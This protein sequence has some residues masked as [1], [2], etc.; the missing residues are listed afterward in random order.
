MEVIMEPPLR[1]L[2]KDSI[3]VWIWKEVIE[4]IIG[5]AVLI[6][7]FILDRMFSW[8]VWAGWILYG[9]VGLTVMGMIWAVFKVKLLQK[10]W[11]YGINEDFLY[12]KSGALKEEYKVIPMTK[13]QS[14]STNEGPLLKKY[15]LSS[16]EVST[17]GRMH[18][19]PALPKAEA[20]KLRQQIALYSNVEEEDE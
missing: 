5:T 18:V 6:V 15:N 9:L 3:K 17:I 2:S 13:V 12:V 4:N 7:L 16:V 8:P 20:Q 14:V 1:R 10:Q 19:I 11:R